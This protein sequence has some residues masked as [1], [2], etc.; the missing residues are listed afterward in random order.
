M[1][2]VGNWRYNLVIVMMICF[3]L[4]GVGQNWENLGNVNK[5]ESYSCCEVCDATSSRQSQNWKCTKNVETIRFCP[6]PTWHSISTNRIVGPSFSNPVHVRRVLCSL[7]Q[8][9]SKN[10]MEQLVGAAHAW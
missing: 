4:H 2:R 10:S 5:E 8:C 3:S 6:N 7:P 9:E 1:K